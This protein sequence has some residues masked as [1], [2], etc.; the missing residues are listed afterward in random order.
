MYTSFQSHLFH[1][2]KGYYYNVI[3]RFVW[4]K[5]MYMAVVYPEPAKQATSSPKLKVLCVYGMALPDPRPYTY[6]LPPGALGPLLTPHLNE[7]RTRTSKRKDLFFTGK[8]GARANDF[9][10]E[11][12]YR[13]VHK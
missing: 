9:G 7:P 2:M 1:G 10:R 11:T 4:G 6:D 5:C 13:C 3:R 8:H 12:L